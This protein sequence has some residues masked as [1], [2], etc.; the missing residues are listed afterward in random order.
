MRDFGLITC[1]YWLQYEFNLRCS[2]IGGELGVQPQCILSEEATELRT[3]LKL[4]SKVFL[5]TPTAE[6]LQD[7]ITHSMSSESLLVL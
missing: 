2:E 1:V 4:T 7:A 3:D 5:S 6:A